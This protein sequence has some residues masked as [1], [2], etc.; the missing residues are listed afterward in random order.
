MVIAGIPRLIGMFASVEARLRIGSTPN[1]LDASRAA[2]TTLDLMLVSPEGRFPI[3]L[4]STLRLSPEAALSEFSSH[5]MI[6]CLEESRQ[7]AA[8]HLRKTSV[9]IHLSS[10]RNDVD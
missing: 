8:T 4:T 9:N 5:G 2:I 3:S 7:V 1:V 6:Y 10:F